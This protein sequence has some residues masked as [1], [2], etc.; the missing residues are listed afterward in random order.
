MFK[1]DQI[2]ART[3]TRL[4]KSSSVL[5]S[6]E[7]RL[8]PSFPAARGYY[9]SEDT[10]QVWLNRIRARWYGDLPHAD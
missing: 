1:R 6:R 5:L 4:D 3:L 7:Q 10:N 9:E 2:W 8:T